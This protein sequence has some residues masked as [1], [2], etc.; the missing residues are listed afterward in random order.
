MDQNKIILPAEYR[1]ISLAT[2]YYSRNN[3]DKKVENY[4]FLITSEKDSGGFFD[5][6]TGQIFLPKK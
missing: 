4:F 6:T 1:K 3:R 2:R 5:I